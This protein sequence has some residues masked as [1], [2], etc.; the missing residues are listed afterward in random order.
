MLS[1]DLLPASLLGHIFSFA[2]SNVLPERRESKLPPT[3]TLHAQLS[4][5]PSI[6]IVG[7]LTA[8]A[9]TVAL[10]LLRRK[11][12]DNSN[13]AL[14]E[15]TVLRIHALAAHQ[16]YRMPDPDDDPGTFSWLPFSRS[17]RRQSLF[18]F[19]LFLLL[20]LAALAYA[21][22]K[23]WLATL[24]EKRH[25][26][27]WT[28]TVALSLALAKIAGPLT[29]FVLMLVP[30]VRAT[31]RW[32]MLLSIRPLYL[33]HA[34]YMHITLT[35]H[36]TF[37]TLTLAHPIQRVLDTGVAFVASTWTV[38]TGYRMAAARVARTHTVAFKII[39][40]LADLGT[41]RYV[42]LAYLRA[43]GWKFLKH[44]I[45]FSL[46][47]ASRHSVSTQKLRV[48]FGPALAVILYELY[49]YL[50]YVAPRTEI[51]IALEPIRK[52][53]DQTQILLQRIAVEQ[54]DFKRSFIQTLD[55]NFG[56]RAASKPSSPT[57]DRL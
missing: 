33:F 29:R 55:Q 32:A 16:P 25:T 46:E 11:P 12:K 20:L 15:G 13:V 51:D 24:A 30:F 22:R 53:L 5:S 36:T 10:L 23:P 56:S 1:L 54:V 39:S 7:T 42:P 31:H 28:L 27:S 18:I 40:R 38:L 43:W 3:P 9:L 14:S 57:S 50:T 26:L 17:P 21:F 19:W 34:V 37:P 48:M 44:V 45:V 35:L 52:T 6:A 2:L 4:P 41:A 8:F 47:G 49:K